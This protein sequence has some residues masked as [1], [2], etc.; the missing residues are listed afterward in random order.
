MRPKG[1][2]KMCF[3]FW[4]KGLCAA[5]ILLVVPALLVGATEQYRMSPPTSAA[6]TLNTP[7]EASTLLQE[8][9]TKAIQVR[10][11]AD[12]LETFN[13]DGELMPWRADAGVLTRAKAQV[14]AMDETLYRLRAMRSEA[15]PWQQRAID[16][17]AP[18]VIELTDYVQDA[19][20]NLNNN[21]LTVHIL[22]N[23]YTQDADYM[24]QRANTI[25]HSIGQFEKYAT[26]RTEIQQL[27]P[28]LGMKVAS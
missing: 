25:A 7:N 15:L 2:T 8:M 11:L 5:A 18:K 14:N 9:K 20:Q 26:A 16:R 21:H 27:S 6:Y 23:S 10:N 13:R 24:Y 28:K 4:L 22:D 17:V 1:D 12:Q 19:I 3:R